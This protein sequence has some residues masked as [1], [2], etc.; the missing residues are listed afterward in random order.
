MSLR[1]Y[2]KLNVGSNTLNEPNDRTISLLVSFL[3]IPTNTG[4]LL[5]FARS[6][7]VNIRSLL[8][9]GSIEAALFLFVHFLFITRVY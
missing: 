8:K 3:A 6:Q 7:Y 2:R 9:K 5:C 4:V 1:V